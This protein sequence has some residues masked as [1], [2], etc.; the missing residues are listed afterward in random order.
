[1]QPHAPRSFLPSPPCSLQALP[2]G[3]EDFRSYGRARRQSMTQQSC[4][5]LPKGCPSLPIPSGPLHALFA[6][7]DDGHRMP[8]TPPR[9]YG[10][11]ALPAELLSSAAQPSPI[12]TV[13]GL[14]HFSEQSSQAPIRSPAA[15]TAARKPQQCTPPFALGMLVPRSPDAER[16][17]AGRAPRRQPGPLL[18][19]CTPT[20][21]SPRSTNGQTLLS[22][23]TP[24]SV[25]R[26]GRRRPS[27][28]S[29][30]FQDMPVDCFSTAGAPSRGACSPVRCSAVVSQ[31]SGN[32]SRWDAATSSRVPTT[33]Q[34]GEDDTAAMNRAEPFRPVR[35]SYP[36]A[37]PALSVDRVLTGNANVSLGKRL[38]SEQ[39]AAAVV[40]PFGSP[41]RLRVPSPQPFALGLTPMTDASR[42]CCSCTTDGGHKRH[43][44]GRARYLSFMDFSLPATPAES[45]ATPCSPKQLAVYSVV[46]R[47]GL[48][49]RS[50]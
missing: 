27:L 18:Q 16:R 30:G 43:D 41:P 8:L 20:L 39:P 6:V 37:I 26:S 31:S 9:A 3:P 36:C 47:R 22:T 14:C 38:L 44:D 49:S 28:E 23:S 48:Q 2:L 29:H 42:D 24:Q 4:P 46:R 11:P 10:R 19:P 12:S 32:P 33:P 21:L 1:M 5:V 40:D 50:S 25:L 45:P 7:P 17:P 34:C 13:F 35:S 15:L